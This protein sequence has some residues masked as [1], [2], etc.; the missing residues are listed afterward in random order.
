MKNT[1]ENFQ[2]SKNNGHMDPQ[3]LDGLPELTGWYWGIYEGGDECFL[4]RVY[5]TDDVWYVEVMRVNWDH[6]IPICSKEWNDWK[7]CRMQPPEMPT[8][9]EQERPRQ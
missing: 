6:P 3:W 2:N 9:H 1:L 8:W 5:C 7:W 4:S